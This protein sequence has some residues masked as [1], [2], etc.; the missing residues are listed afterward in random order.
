M[1]F[2]AAAIPALATLAAGFMGKKAADKARESNELLARRNEEMQREFAR[3][4]VRWKV[5][6]ARAA[7]INPLAA[8]GASTAAYSP[9]AVGEP[10]DNSMANMVHGMGQDIGRA[11]TATKTAQ[12]REMTALQLS[13]L[14][15][16][17]DGKLI[18]NQIRAS[19]L[20]KLNLTGPAFPGSDNFIPGQGNSGLV[21]DKPLERV[22]SSP[23]RPAQEA[24][25]RPDVSYSRTDTGLTPMVPESLS[26]SLEDDFL[27]KLMW[28]VRNQLL[29]NLGQGS[30]PRHMLPKGFNSWEWSTARQEWQPSKRSNRAVEG[31]RSFTKF[32]RGF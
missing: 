18:D 5:E 6:D 8:L 1:A 2:W 22:V 23:G 19:Q 17:L 3:F 11:I 9:I 7:G 24:G 21:V 10:A 29:P 28:R 4:G 15:A 16:D 31:G 26:E 25:W 30:P 20:K 12:E 13:A 32:L 27:G 14:K